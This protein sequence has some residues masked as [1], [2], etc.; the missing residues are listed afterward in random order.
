MTSPAIKLAKECGAMQGLD[1]QGHVLIFDEAEVD[2]F[3]A[4]AQAQSLRDA[5][6]RM[7]KD[8][9]TVEC[10]D[11]LRFLRRMAEELEKKA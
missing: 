2:R 8:Y 6:E 1:R 11:S 10:G 3:Y 4:L 7:I 9:N 5:A